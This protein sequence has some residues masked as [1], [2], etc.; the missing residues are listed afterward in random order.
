MNEEQ[1]IQ[2][3]RDS[4]RL[5]MEQVQEKGVLIFVDD[6]PAS[7]EEV[8]LRCVQ[9]QTVYMPDYVLNE[10]GGLKEVR[11]DRIYL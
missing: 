2:Q 7:P 8:A 5:Q 6:E 3:I 11:F 4:V 9:E 1:D 10:K